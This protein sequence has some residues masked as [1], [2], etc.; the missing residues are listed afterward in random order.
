MRLYRLG[1]VSR[2]LKH[3]KRFAE[4]FLCRT[5]FV[6][7]DEQRQRQAGREIGATKRIAGPVCITDA[8]NGIQGRKIL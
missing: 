6:H 3:G 7:L 4:T 2:A 8:K 5:E 1:D